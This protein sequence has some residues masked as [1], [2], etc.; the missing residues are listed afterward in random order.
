VHFIQ[1]GREVPG[2]FH[3]I[4][5]GVPGAFHTIGGYLVHFENILH[6]LQTNSCISV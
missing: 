5:E 3:T 6:L 2:T 4:G 1:Y